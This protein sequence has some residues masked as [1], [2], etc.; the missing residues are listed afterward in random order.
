MPAGGG[1]MRV[2]NLLAVATVCAM[3]VAAP[4]TIARGSNYSGTTG[5]TGCTGVNEADNADH[6]F[7]YDDVTAAMDNATDWVRTNDLD[8]TDLYTSL[9]PLTSVTDVVVY[10]RDYTTYCD[11]P[12]YDPAQGEGV[13]GLATCVSLNVADECEKH[14]VRYEQ[15]FTSATTVSNRR[16][17]ACHENGHAVGLLHRS[18][19]CMQQ[20]YPKPMNDYSSHDISHIDANY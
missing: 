8:P 5:V 10:E 11:L 19:S 16:G 3:S 7:Y 4:A 18:G 15:E 14:S 1:F 12:W 9:V 2:L 20:N 17:L 13:V 6:T